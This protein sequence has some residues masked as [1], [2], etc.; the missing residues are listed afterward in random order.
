VVAS[1]VGG[2]QYTVVPEHWVTRPTKGH[3]AFAAAIDR[4]LSDPIYRNKLAQAEKGW[5]PSS[6][7][8]VLPIKRTIYRALEQPVK[9]PGA[10]PTVSA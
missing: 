6:V 2:L 9:A 10:N 8:K 4:I 5:K 1:D 7:G 3:L